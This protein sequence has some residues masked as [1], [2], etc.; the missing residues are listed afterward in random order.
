M[1]NIKFQGSRLSVELHYFGFAKDR[2]IYPTPRG[3]RLPHRMLWL[4]KD[5]KESLLKV[6]KE[7][8]IKLWFSDIFR[9]GEASLRARSR[10]RGVQR[11]SK[12]AHNFGLAVDLHV[13]K[14]LMQSIL[15]KK[16]LDLLL[17]EYGWYCHRKDHA[18]RFESWHYNY[19]G[20][21]ACKYIR[22]ED[23]HHSSSIERKIQDLYGDELTLD[24]F[25]SQVCLKQL[26]F[27]GGAIDGIHGPITKQATSQFQ[28]GWLLP[29]TRRVDA[30]TQRTLAYVC[31]EFARIND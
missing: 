12:S 26:R 25:E 23:R 19:L 28:K 4:H 16:A 15:T 27:Y 13:D 21:N 29:V 20:D 8:S 14:V 17:E 6:A 2:G 3:T 22:D 30:L 31:G 9:S 10:K 5:A 7:T 11:P 18:L 24:K 1:D